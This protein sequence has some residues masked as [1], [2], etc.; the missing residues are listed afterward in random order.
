[1]PNPLLNLVRENAHNCDECGTQFDV[2]FVASVRELTFRHRTKA[3]RIAFQ[4]DRRSTGRF[5]KKL[6]PTCGNYDYG[7]PLH[8][9]KWS[10][11]WTPLDNAY[12]LQ[13][14]QRH[15]WEYN[16]TMLKTFDVETVRAFSLNDAYEYLVT[17]RVVMAWSED[18]IVYDRVVF[19][20]GKTREETIWQYGQVIH[21]FNGADGI[22]VAI[23][24]VNRRV[25]AYQS[26]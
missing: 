12:L 21:M 19:I 11:W 7:F 17:D 8:H 18:I 4:D 13:V 14:K 6:C 5:M 9:K 24:V 26:K 3:E 16:R 20:D 10:C 25:L 2:R 22:L 23:G 15:M 1:M